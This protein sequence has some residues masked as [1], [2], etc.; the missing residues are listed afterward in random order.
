MS[1]V[2][3]ERNAVNQ[4]IQN[5]LEN[6]LYCAICRE[7]YID[8]LILNCAHSFCKFCLN[9]WLSKRVGC[10][11]CRMVVVFQTENLAL[12]DIVDKMM[13]TSSQEFQLKRNLSLEA[14][15]AAEEVQRENAIKPMMEKRSFSKS[16]RARKIN[17]EQPN[18]IT[19]WRGP[20]GATIWRTELDRRGKIIRPD[21]ADDYSGPSSSSESE[22]F[23]HYALNFENYS[24]G[25][26]SSS[27]NSTI[28]IVT[29][30][31]FEEEQR[32]RMNH[33]NILAGNIAP[34]S[35][36]DF[37]IGEHDHSDS[38][39]SMQGIESN[40]DHSADDIFG[41]WRL[42][43]RRH[44]DMSTDD[45]EEEQEEEEVLESD[46]S[47]EDTDSTSS[48]ATSSDET[49]D[50]GDSLDAR[51]VEDSRDSD[52]ISSA[53]DLSSSRNS[54]DSVSSDTDIPEVR[55]SESLDLGSDSD[56]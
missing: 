56:F 42:V 44:V 20:N 34:E 49:S 47:V 22:D 24:P 26:A 43:R 10:P 19:S 32:V 5:M 8:P 15:V 3:I 27:S 48:D 9:Q 41:V 11:S 2:Q 37:D 25:F 23:E 52:A 50:D 54:T 45:D 7:I 6:E 51:I 30:Q 35:D 46:E 38:D 16:G 36:E 29:D 31:S 18:Y 53:S 40:S 14:R 4:D 33:L 39:S 17:D 12:K 28:D 55:D 21:E 13:K 1:N